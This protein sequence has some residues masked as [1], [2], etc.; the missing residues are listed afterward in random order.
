MRTL[1]VLLGPLLDTLGTKQSFTPC[2]YQRLPNHTDAYAARV[3]VVDRLANLA[4][5]RYLNI[6]NIGDRIFKLVT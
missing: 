4:F 3:V 6:L 1:F 5:N 2:A